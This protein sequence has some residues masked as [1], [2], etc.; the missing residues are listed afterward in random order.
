[1]DTLLRVAVW[2]PWSAGAVVGTGE[3]ITSLLEPRSCFAPLRSGR[4]DRSRSGKEE[5]GEDWEEKKSFEP[6]VLRWSVG[7]PAPT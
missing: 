1:M 6:E 2:V 5:C 3:H 4:V 7:C